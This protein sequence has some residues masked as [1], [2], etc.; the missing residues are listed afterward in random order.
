LT[1]PVLKHTGKKSSRSHSYPP[2]EK[3]PPFN[4]PPLRRIYTPPKE[5]KSLFPQPLSVRMIN[6]TRHSAVAKQHR[7]ELY[8]YMIHKN[9]K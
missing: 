5:F 4:D 2:A 8:W 7:G 1:Q 6:D 9:R 3:P